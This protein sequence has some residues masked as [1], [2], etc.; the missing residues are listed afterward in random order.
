MEERAKEVF[1]WIL[2]NINGYPKEE[3]EEL[4]IENDY[5]F[6]QLLDILEFGKKYDEV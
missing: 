2:F 4:D 3:I 6:G 5:M 1:K